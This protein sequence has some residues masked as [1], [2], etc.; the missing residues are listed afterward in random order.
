ME[1]LRDL[2]FGLRLLRKRPGFTVAAALALA[3]GIGATT[4]I[5]SAVDVLLLR[6]LPYPAAERLVTLR[7]VNRGQGQLDSPDN[8]VSPVQFA[9]FRDKVSSFEDVAGWWYPDLNLTGHDRE[10]ERIATADVT[11]NFFSVLG[12]APVEGRPFAP[13]E[14]RYGAEPVVVIGH[15]LWTRRYGADR[16]LVG[17]PIYL[18][19]RETLVVGIAPPGFRYPR[20][21]EVWRPLGWDPTQ[22]NRGARFFGVVA[23]LAE[24]KTLEE[25]RAE[26][27]A[28]T[29]LLARDFP[30]TNSGWGASVIP[31]L[32]SELGRTRQGLLV[33]LGA[34]GF[35]LLLACANVANLLMAQGMGRGDEVAIRTALGAN[36][37]RLAAQFLAESL[38]LALLGGSAGLALAVYGVAA[39]KRIVPVMVPRIDLVGVDLRVLG[40]TLG[41]VL[42][43]AFV[44]G[45][46]PA[47]QISKGAPSGGRTTGRRTRD[48]FVVTQVAV[49][50]LMLVGAGLLMRSF[51]RL[52]REDPGF[53][54]IRST[55]FNL[56]V[57]SSSYQDWSEVTDFY[58]RLVER[59]SE[60]GGVRGA[61]VTAFL[62][63]D[64]GWPIPFTIEGRA[65]VPEGEEP[66]VQYH[67]VSP[68][69]FRVMGIP[70]LRGRDL[71][72]RDLATGPGVVVVNDAA[73]R[74]YWPG[75]DPIGAR[76]LTEARQFGPLGRVM[77]ESL[78][79]EVVGI[80]ADVKNA[81]LQNEPEAAFYF[82]FR[83]F[84]YRSMN[85]VVRSQ[86]DEAELAP[87]LK[88][89]VWGL[90]A[91]LPVSAMRTLE[92]DLEEAVAS[93]RFVLVTLAAFALLALALA[94][95]GT[96]GVLSCA[97]GE[98]KREIA[99]RMALGARPAAVKHDLLGRA[100][101]LASFGI[102]LGGAAAWLLGSYLQSFLFGIS[103]HDPLAF[104]V[105]ALVLVA[106]AL[107]ASYLPARRASRA[108]PWSTL[109]AE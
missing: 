71:S 19:G 108:D 99:I 27:D 82:S 49:A 45:T 32:H 39:L 3:L 101:L 106:T 89:A 23:R 97:A 30:A 41:V 92:A 44:F 8:N 16:S 105:S 90:D 62:P 47:W 33:L 88:E 55:T 63:L 9:D 12:V 59:I 42:L 69:Y 67:S 77:P 54:G 46:I 52:L 38:A 43:T 40:F 18:D 37:R 20:Q 98:R 29:T 6:P 15:A 36:R 86:A 100:L 17:R 78:E 109:R 24:G 107:A 58:A 51:E 91:D 35:V 75:E 65:P 28:L 48:L 79:L 72:E 93:E 21:T 64:P 84:A 22:H 14:D 53:T 85:V 68:G 81:S 1:L 83:Q 34:V 31:L 102:A 66:K 87:A 60:V 74:R 50:L 11:D 76:V 104:G 5:F 26:V 57:P 61:A 96:Y 94:A 56:Q 70:L 4:T 73:R 95:V 80:V 10:P 25:A 103:A 13:G 2:G 7:E